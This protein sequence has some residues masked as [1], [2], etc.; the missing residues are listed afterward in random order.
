MLALLDLLGFL[1]LLCSLVQLV[2][3]PPQ[4]KVAD[5]GHKR[6]KNRGRKAVSDG[7]REKVHGAPAQHA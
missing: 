3:A 4:R 6:I 2:G 5:L 1:L 7:S